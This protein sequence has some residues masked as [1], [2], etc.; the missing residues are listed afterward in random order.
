M[1]GEFFHEYA[2]APE[3]SPK[4][5]I[6]L[7]GDE[8]EDVI[9][10]PAVL[11]DMSNLVRETQAMY[12]SHHYNSY[13]FLLSL[14]QKGGGGGLEHHE[15]SDNGQPENAYT[16]D[17]TT[18]V[19]SYLLA[20][21]FTHSWN[22]KYRR[23]AGLATADYAEPMK[24]ELLWVYEGLTDYLGNVLGAR[25]GFTTPEHYR[26]WL[27]LNAATLDYKS[28]RAWRS[29]DDTAISV[30]GLRGSP[31]WANWRRS[32][33]YYQE[34]D[35]FWLDVDTTIRKLTDNRK[36]L[37]DFLVLF[38]AKGGNTGPMVLPYTRDELLAEL[39]QVVPNDWTK[40]FHDR[41]DAITPHVDLE[42]VTQG[43]YKLV[44]Q[45]HPSYYERA[46]LAQRG[47]GM[48]VWFSL[49]LAVEKDGTL[50]DVRIGSPA[51]KARLVP[52]M[53]LLA[54][55]GLLFSK[56]SLLKAVKDSPTQPITAIV[57]ND[58]LVTV[59]PIDYHD[60]P[61]YPT[62]VRVEGTPAYLDDIT[63]PLATHPAQ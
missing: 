49:G 27:A 51:D 29:T 1:A 44:Y 25:A 35:M 43:G 23:P 36:N 61:R 4:H 39:N 46:F 54:V 14:T 53:K 62:L 42:G 50:T 34:G 45:D 13:H 2:L 26:E 38:V 22:G 40:F 59:N 10:R 57:Q 63:A 58:N 48:D 33:D 9:L 18:M 47:S 41:L 37:H 28:G 20:H 8:P 31:A 32:T 56:D 24:G 60:G 5:Y 21:E 30:A 11:A 3:V 55:N 52:G 12:S 17:D 16:T 15:S 6:D 7:F 19:N